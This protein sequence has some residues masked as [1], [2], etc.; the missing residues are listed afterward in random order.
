[1]LAP[2]RIWVPEP[3]LVSLRVPEPS[4]NTPEKLFKPESFTPA[5]EAARV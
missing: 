1:M 2:E 5:A 4:D 3:S